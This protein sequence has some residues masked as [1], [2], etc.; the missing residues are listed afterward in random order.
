MPDKAALSGWSLVAAV[1]SFL[2]FSQLSAWLSVSGGSRPPN[3][4]YRLTVTSP[5]FCSKF[6]ADSEEHTFP[7]ANVGQDT[8]IKVSSS[9]RGS[10]PPI[11]SSFLPFK[12]A[13]LHL[14]CK[15]IKSR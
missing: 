9:I 1:R 10:K 2:H 6:E 4:I 3:I 12:V 7:V 13:V 15:N 14:T 5:V 8:A 11:A